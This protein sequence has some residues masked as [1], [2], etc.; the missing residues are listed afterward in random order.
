MDLELG[1]YNSDAL[2]S[3]LRRR[4]RNINVDVKPAS[5]EGGLARQPIYQVVHYDEMSNSSH[6]FFLDM[7]KSTCA[8]QLGFNLDA[9]A[10]P[11][12]LAGG[13]RAMRFKDN[14]RVYASLPSLPGQLVCSTL[15]APGVVNLAGTRYITLRCI[16]IESHLLGSFSSENLNVG[17][18]IFKL[19][20]PYEVANLKFDFYNF[21][22]K[23]F[24]PIGKLNRITLRFETSSAPYDF[25]GVNHQILISIKHYVMRMPPLLNR[26]ILNPDYDPD[27]LRFQIGHHQRIGDDEDDDSDYDDAPGQHQQQLQLHNAHDNGYMYHSYWWFYL[28]ELASFEW[29]DG[30][31]WGLWGSTAGASRCP[32]AP[33][34][35]ACKIWPCTL[36][37]PLT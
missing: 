36:E 6:L 8:V 21:V 30:L 3:H 18:G 37:R 5:E 12:V 14:R 4:L 29:L 28:C 2:M 25:K 19:N 33:Q 22:K 24:H 35:P 1:N 23:P 13:Y 32:A 20:S 11:H 15:V 31:L 17:L 10:R 16:E 9:Q 34:T 27:G 26:S 7:N